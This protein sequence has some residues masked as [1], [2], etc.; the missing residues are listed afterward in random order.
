MDTRLVVVSLWAED[1]SAMVRFYQ[2]VI[3]LRIREHHHDPPHFD[4]GGASLVILKGTPQEPL[5]P[6]PERFPILAIA[7]DDLDKMVDRLRETKVEL[8]WEIKGG[9][10]SR[11]VMFHDPGGN[12]V[13]LV[14][15]V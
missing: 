12:L 9:P 15:F 7:V 6:E 14:E 10:G 4:L 3:G 1:V 5:D 8:P 2:D 11:Y 13:E